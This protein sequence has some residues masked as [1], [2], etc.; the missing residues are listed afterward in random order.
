MKMYVRPEM[1]VVSIETSSTL[2][3]GSGI[4]SEEVNCYGEYT[5]AEALSPKNGFKSL[6]DED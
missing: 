4:Q 2:L 6:W 3:A 5:G 1:K